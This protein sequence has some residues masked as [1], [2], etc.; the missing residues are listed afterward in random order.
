MHADFAGFGQHA[1]HRTARQD[2]REE[3]DD[4]GRAEQRR[5]DKEK[6]SNE[7]LP[8][9]SERGIETIAFVICDGASG[10]FL[11]FASPFNLRFCV[12]LRRRPEC[13]SSL[14]WGLF[15]RSGLDVGRIR[16][17][18]GRDLSEPRLERF[19]VAI[20]YWSDQ[21]KIVKGRLETL[22]HSA[23]QSMILVFVLLA[24]F[25]RPSLAFW[26]VLGIPIAF[27]GALAAMPFL[28][29]T[30]NIVSLFAFILVLGVV[31]D[32]AIVIGE[33]IHSW[34][35][36]GVDPKIAAV[37]GA[38]EVSIPVIF[39]VLTTMLAFVPMLFG[40]GHSAQWQG[41]IAL[42]VIVVLG[43]SLIE[44]KLILP[45]HLSHHAR[46][47]ARRMLTFFTGE[48]ATQTL[49]WPYRC[50]MRFH[51]WFNEMVERAVATLYQPVL[52]AALRWRYLTMSIFL[53]ALAITVGWI[54]GGR[55]VRIPFPPVESD[56]VTCRLTMQEGTPFEVTARH[57]DHIESIV[58]QLRRDYRTAD[59]TSV[60]EDI[61]TSIGGQ[62][63]ASS[64]SRG[65]QGQTHV[66]EVT[67]Y[68][69][70][71]ELRTAR[72]ITFDN[73]ELVNDWRK[74]IGEIVGAEELTF[75]A[76]LFRGSDPVDIELTSNDNAAL[77]EA[78]GKVRDQLNTYAGLFD[79][80]DSLDESREEI[81]LKIRPEAEQFGLTMADLARQVRQAFFGEEVQ[82]IQRSRDEVRV[83]LRYPL[84]DR[85]SLA[86]LNAMRIRTP[87]GGE[88]PFSTVA[89]AEVGKSF[90][91]IQRID[92]SRSVNIRADADKTAVDLDAIR[93]D[94]SVFLAGLMEQ[95]P[96]MSYSFEGEAKD[97]RE[98]EQAEWAGTILIVFG[99]YAMLAIPFRSYT[100]PL[101]VML[102]I[103]YGLIG[104]VIGHLIEG[105][106]LSKL[107]EF[108]ML[109]LSGVVVNDSLVLVDF[110]NRKVREGVKVFD[111][112]RSAGAARFRPIFLTSITTFGGLYPLLSLESTQAKVLIPMA[113]SLAYGVMFATFITLFLVPVSYLILEDLKRPFS[114]KNLEI[115][116][117]IEEPHS[118][119]GGG[120]AP[121]LAAPER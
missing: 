81:R 108:G 21:S 26:V 112:V 20:S 5:N 13:L 79:V 58:E 94:L 35:Q 47:A 73:M 55:L 24:L 48:K 119:P 104:A 62:G 93:A 34:Q 95:H 110:I 85:K 32:D 105:M 70:A 106:P 89:E 33:N 28:G 65:S 60:V 91:R 36:R 42:I 30:I 102:A 88:V 115:E 64:R 63:L 76:E 74:R 59:G 87:E 39:G 6:T 68:L 16:V 51:R 120:T 103:P 109:A 61:L 117:P 52:D 11:R 12:S 116:E 92:R 57:I 31:V 111:A 97:E 114:L 1:F 78:A 96:G 22:L 113:V 90:P 29:V 18:V 49:T 71:R 25:L 80:T 37:E 43:F 41:Q 17:G 46:H 100:Q 101:M 27:L 7:I 15:R 67:F 118:S 9:A 45:A 77:S 23:W 82:R 99:I 2:A 56:R 3:K 98:A 86:A 19:N 14:A 38:R 10:I 83:M 66:G 69:M 8:H 40:T 84:A 4:Q 75:R 72:G 54:A 44:S 50:F 107:S 53:A 121:G